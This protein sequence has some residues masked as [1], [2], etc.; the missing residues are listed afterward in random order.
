MDSVTSLTKP[1]EMI[2]LSPSHLKFY[3]QVIL[4][5]FPLDSVNNLKNVRKC[6]W[7]GKVKFP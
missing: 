1:L 2:F 4:I 3:Q 7:K 5:N 6:D